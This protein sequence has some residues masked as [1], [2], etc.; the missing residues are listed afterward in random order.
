MRP[1]KNKEDLRTHTVNTRLNDEE[2]KVLD[3]KRGKLQRGAFLRFL[4]Q[5][6]REV[7][8]VNKEIYAETARWA[9]AVNQLARKLNQ[10]KE[11]E[12]LEEIRGIL[13]QF[14]LGLLGLTEGKENDKQD[15]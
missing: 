13:S 10:G 4:L 5:G 2:L 11:V 1:P 7:P 3:T 9:S 8:Q 12:S 14:R 6:R 15:K